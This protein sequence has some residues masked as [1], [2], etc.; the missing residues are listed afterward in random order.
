MSFQNTSRE[1]R[2]SAIALLFA[3][4]ATG[5]LLVLT[6]DRSVKFD[7][8]IM[9]AALFPV[10]AYLSGNLRLFSLWGLLL[11]IPFD[12][13]ERIGPILAKL[14]G[15][16]SFRFE[17]S[18]PFWLV[19]LAYIGHEIWTGQRKGIRIPKVSY[20]W[21][22]IALIGVWAIIV[23]PWHLTAAHETVRMLKVWLLFIC[24]SN[25]LTTRRRIIQCALA[26][27]ATVILQ[28]TVGL[29]QYATRHYF[30]LRA[31]GEPELATLNQLSRE[32]VSGEHVFR[33]GA[34][35][36]HPNI[37][38]VFLAATLPL[39]IALF[40]VKTTQ[41]R[42]LIFLTGIILGIPA[43]VATL[44]RSGWLSFA[45][46]CVLLAG[47]LLL[48]HGFRQRSILA[49]AVAL[50]VMAGM[51]A[52]F[53]QP[54]STRI[55]DSQPEAVE[56]RLQWAEEALKMIAVKPILGWGL[57]SYVFALP[58]FTP[59]GARGARAFYKNG[60]NW[61]PA[62]HNAYLLSCAETGIVGLGLYLSLF[63]ILG[64]T[65]LRNFRVKDEV[66]FAINAGCLCS[67]AAFLVDG[68][69]SPSLRTNSI[70]RVFWVLGGMIMAIYYWRLR[71]ESGDSGDG[72]AVGRNAA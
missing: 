43:L 57:N 71:E 32:S 53:Y 21:L 50:L 41:V 5:L 16:T 67:L 40:L 60:V 30:G 24:I 62:V 39:I 36:Q 10:A 46:C 26:L 54:I 59:Y 61:A 68:M 64:W 52:V 72:E 48:H 38:G 31:L 8:A 3:F 34:F 51:V 45:I 44:S 27:T 29:I 13:S 69:F 35:M 56:G 15:E 7:V 11:T 19:L 25:E 49:G 20:P 63:V 28:S 14:G 66:L 70:L 33:A 55:F 17:M 4:L 12:L 2:Q 23:G 58:P 9:A 6:L 37:F 1:L 47:I 42:R 18:D 22:M 65:A